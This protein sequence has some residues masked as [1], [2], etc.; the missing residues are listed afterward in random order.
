MF[1][2]QELKNLEIKFT[3]AGTMPAGSVF[4]LTSAGFAAFLVS[5]NNTEVSLGGSVTSKLTF[6]RMANSVTAT[7]IGGD[8]PQTLQK[9]DT[10]IVT[11][12][13][14]KAPKIED[15]ADWTCS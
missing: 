3:A 15:D 2:E 12:K 4:T 9:G 5:N 7:V 11:I 6:A 14:Y 13:T 10:I 8:A 1:S